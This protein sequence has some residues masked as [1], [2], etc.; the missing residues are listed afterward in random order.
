M[1]HMTEARRQWRDAYRMAR[2]TARSAPRY[3]FPWIAA[4]VSRPLPAAA[5]AAVQERQP[6]AS[7]GY[8]HLTSVSRS[9]MARLPGLRCHMRRLH[10]RRSTPQPKLHSTPRWR[11]L[12]A[13]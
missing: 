9:V 7:S 6:S 8:P 12:A 4:A 2:R 13:R 5:F 10:P 11:W 1:T 3:E